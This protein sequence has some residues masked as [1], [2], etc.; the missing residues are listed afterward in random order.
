[1]NGFVY[2]LPPA[3]VPEEVKC[4][5]KD[6]QGY[7]ELEVSLINFITNTIETNSG[8]LPEH[9]IISV[10]GIKEKAKKQNTND[11]PLNGIIINNKNSA[12]VN[13]KHKEIGSTTK[14]SS[15]DI[16][17]NVKH[18][19]TLDNIQ[20]KI[21]WCGER[22]E[23]AANLNI[24][25]NQNQT[26]KQEPQTHKE[27]CKL[28][29]SKR[30]YNQQHFKRQ[31]Q[32]DHNQSKEKQANNRQHL[33]LS[34]NN[35][36]RYRICTSGA[37]FLEY[38]SSCKPIEII[39]TASTTSG[40][41]ST[42]AKPLGQAQLRLPL[43]LLK[44]FKHN[45]VK[46]HNFAYKT[47]VYT[48]YKTNQETLDNKLVKS[49]EI[50]LIFK[51]LFAPTAAASATAVAAAQPG[52]H[53]LHNNHCHHHH[54]HHHLVGGKANH[55]MPED[56][57]GDIP[58]RLTSQTKSEEIVEAM[59]K[60]DAKLVAYLAGETD[61]TSKLTNC[62]EEN[63]VNLNLENQSFTN[64]LED[65]LPATKFNIFKSI[66]SIKLEMEALT[67]QPEGTKC[68]HLLQNEIEPIFTVECQLSNE[69]IKQVPRHDMFHIMQFESEKFQSLTQCTRFGQQ[70]ERAVKLA[71]DQELSDEN[72][73]ETVVDFGRI[74][75][76]VWWREPGT[77]LNE[78]LGMGVLEINDLYNASLLEQCKR[79]E[80]QRRGK[81]LAC[82]YFKIKLQRDGMN[83]TAA[84]IKRELF[85]PQQLSSSDSDSEKT[86]ATD[87]KQQQQTA[88]CG[89][90][91]A[92]AA[93]AATSSSSKLS[94]TD[95]ASAQN[96]NVKF[97]T[98]NFDD[99][100]SKIRL[101]K[102]FISANETRNLEIS[103]QPQTFLVCRRFWLDE[104]ATAKADTTCKFN[105]QE[106]FSVIN[107]DKFLQSVD[108]Q[109]LHLELW[110]RMSCDDGNGN[111]EENAQPVGVVRMPLHQFFIAYRDAAITNHLCKGKLPVISIDAWAP[112]INCQTGLNVGEI[113]CLLA[114]GSDEQIKN[115]KESRGLQANTT[116][117]ESLLADKDF[118]TKLQ[119]L[120]IP[121]SSKVPQPTK[122]TPP[123]S[124]G[125][126][127][128]AAK[129]KKTSD[130]LDM[131]QKVLMTS[132][133]TAGDCQPPRTATATATTVDTKPSSVTASTLTPLKPTNVKL[134]RFSLEIQKA[135][136]LPLN[137]A[138]KAKKG[139]S[140][141]NASKRFPPNE[142]PSCYVTFQADEGQY[143]TY[144]SHE[145]MVFAT[146]I[147]EKSTHPQ[148]QQ[149]FRLAAS[150]DYLKIPQK[151]FIL[152]V[153]KKSSLDMAQ[154]RQQPTPM[155]DAI[156]GLTALD[157]SAFTRG[158]HIAGTF[159]IVDFNGR[160]NG[161]LLVRCQPLEDITPAI[162]AGN[163]TSTAT[164]AA[165]ATASSA[166]GASV[167]SVID[168][169]EQTLD[170]THL[171][172]GQAIKRK[173]TELEG[174]SQRLRAR[175]GD[176]TGAE[177]NKNFDLQ[178]LND[179]QPMENDANDEFDEFEHDLNTTPLDEEDTIQ[180]KNKEMD[181]QKLKDNKYQGKT[182]SDGNENSE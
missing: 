29:N 4:E 37:L 121:T 119:P 59:K 76:T 68:M 178:S 162:K 63:E 5:Q 8:K 36:L 87:K 100:T 48:L 60:L 40:S 139:Y 11:T 88:Q 16:V 140:K 82:L 85:L 14:D 89:I 167:D 17:G 130:L 126:P 118:I 27:Y 22:K 30:K 152:K 1:M 72:A 26:I 10:K 43:V 169:F 131:L 3:N 122:Q 133:A 57:Q 166:A 182:E 115:L 15:K 103:Q 91:T 110:Q 120:Q 9:K 51:M 109:Y 158:L 58:K 70:A 47:K 135:I 146:N 34:A 148:W 69:L 80:I 141:R 52:E 93:A 53:H 159:N 35:K 117:S 155:E 18:Y 94:A 149:R 151:L 138:S 181:E 38:L 46:G 96:N 164:V 50:Q 180:E 128:T 90:N 56:V 168:Q 64:N 77:C 175:L 39:V 132:P 147:V 78:M 12:S 101:L 23:D 6:L 145:G 61:I 13:E 111:P 107:D 150:I 32:N 143:P 21:V 79:I 84:E 7:L 171:N 33:P 44:K 154:G 124:S 95:K 106:Q 116:F 98:T 55:Q 66:N 42:A 156:I 125:S 25:C 54:R 108:K 134:F 153:L 163:T 24:S 102:G 20:V 28:Y 144:K 97:E 86:P 177:L 123:T 71:I 127:L 73:N 136:G 161:Q 92:V 172:L 112:I 137:P 113:K 114:V 74:H 176:V 170:L 2:K 83:T 65:L 41:C 165:T 81:S 157:L 160:I 173:F 75:F 105:Y 49:G 142:A 104:P 99:E 62:E 129:I 179:W 67:L 45:I 19:H 31:Q 174:I